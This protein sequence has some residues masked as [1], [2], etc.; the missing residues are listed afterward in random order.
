[1]AALWT[2]GVCDAVMQVRIPLIAC[3]SCRNWVHLKCPGINGVQAIKIFHLS[4]FICSK[5][6]SAKWVIFYSHFVDYVA[7]AYLSILLILFDLKILLLLRFNHWEWSTC[8]LIFHRSLASNRY[9][10]KNDIFR[11]NWKLDN[12]PYK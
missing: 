12:S 4:S 8:N 2:C 11:N 7:R 5:Y 6:L 1:M 9:C 10:Q 3:T